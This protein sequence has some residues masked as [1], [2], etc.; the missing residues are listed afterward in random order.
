[1]LDLKVNT[2]STLSFAKDANQN[3]ALALFD[4]GIID[5][6]EVLKAFEYPNWEA[7][8]QRVTERKAQQAQMQESQHQGK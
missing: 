1:M 8:L 7:V 2:G 6:E 4:R 3:K 5:E